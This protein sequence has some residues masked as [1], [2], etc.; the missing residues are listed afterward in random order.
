MMA[1]HFCIHLWVVNVRYPG[2]CCHEQHRG[3]CEKKEAIIKMGIKEEDLPDHYFPDDHPTRGTSNA[4]STGWTKANQKKAFFIVMAVVA[5]Y[6]WH[7]RRYG[8]HQYDYIGNGM[9]FGGNGETGSIGNRFGSFT[10]H[11]AS[12]SEEKKLEAARDARLRRFAGC[13]VSS[14][15]VIPEEEV[16]R[17]RKRSAAL[18]SSVNIAERNQQLGDNG[19]RIMRV[20]DL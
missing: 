8:H 6:I 1:W 19:P 15:N 3:S 11:V 5:V 18:R 17:L 16:L 4:S 13:D 9:R 10:Q 2:H 20:D 12:E 14:P 7:R